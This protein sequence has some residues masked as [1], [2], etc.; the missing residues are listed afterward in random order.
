MEI[1]IVLLLLGLTVANTLC[2][3]KLRNMRGDLESFFDVVTDQMGEMAS[4]QEDMW[5]FINSNY[6]EFLN[7]MHKNYHVQQDENNQ[8]SPSKQNWSELDELKLIEFGN[9][10]NDEAKKRKLDVKSFQPPDIH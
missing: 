1:L 7:H 6:F 4:D 3:L 2:F 9:W 8:F 5:F 10:L